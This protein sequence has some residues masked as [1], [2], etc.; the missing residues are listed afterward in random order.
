MI[1]AFWA[2]EY[3]NGLIFPEYDLISGT[4]NKFAHVDHKNVLRFWWLPVTQDMVGVFP[5]LRVNPLL[6]RHAVELNG[7]KGYVA[8]RVAVEMGGGLLQRKTVKCYVL[9]IEGGP[10]RELYP[11]GTV[12]NI[13]IPQIGETQEILHG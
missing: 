6:R 8:R 11:D 10:R 9:G 3:N 13:A 2:A 1:E 5:G 12:V 7:S 4:I